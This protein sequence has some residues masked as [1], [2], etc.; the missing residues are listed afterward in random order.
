MYSQMMHDP[1]NY[2]N[3]GLMDGQHMYMNNDMIN[4]GISNGMPMAG[5]SY[6]RGM[7]QNQY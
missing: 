2:S 5:S 1:Y 7:D 6:L 3:N 4:H